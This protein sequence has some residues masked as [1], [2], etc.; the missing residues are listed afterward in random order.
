MEDT[1]KITL[2]AKHSLNQGVMVVQPGK[3]SGGSGYYGVENY[4][5]EEKRRLPF[6][7]TP[8]TVFKVRHNTVLDLADPWHSAIWH[9]FLK[10][11]QR[12][13]PNST[14]AANNPFVLYYVDDEESKITAS[15]ST[16]KERLL[17]DKWLENLPPNEKREVCSLLNY[18]TDGSNLLRVEEFLI[19]K[20]HEGDGWRKVKEAKGWMESGYAS[21]V[22]LV[23][24]LI[25]K[26]IL[27]SDNKWFH[28]GGDNGS[29]KVS[30]GDSIEKVIFWMGQ[31]ENIDSV[32]QWMAV[33]NSDRPV[34]TIPT[35]Q[36]DNVFAE[37]DMASIAA[38]PNMADIFLAAENPG[39]LDLLM[40][41]MGNAVPFPP[42]T[43]KPRPAQ[44][45]K[46]VQ[47]AQT[48]QP[49]KK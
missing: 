36:A 23:R 14:E 43:A 20:V 34:L 13:A 25:D 29:P 6:H 16:Y 33:L 8:E 7:I 31:R 42:A 46:T 10:Y 26:R 9:G 45:A 11:D 28:Y 38:P 1:T 37:P 3:K 21:K 27:K 35:E 39:A 24:R 5:E 19:K 44:G 12:I 30:I 48:A 41:E 22:G 15:I 32:R 47:T 18:R 49:V 40:Q 4:S 17:L 2:K